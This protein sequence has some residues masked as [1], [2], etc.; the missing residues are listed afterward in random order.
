[1]EL[2]W[3][4]YAGDPAWTPPLRSEV[5][6]LLDRRANPYFEHASAAYFLAL[7]DGK[8]VGRISAQLC[9]LVQ[10]HMGQG[11]GQWG[12]STRSMTRWSLPPCSAPLKPGCAI[13]V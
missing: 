5:K 9:D 11:T 7:R 1:M 8:P 10:T 3:S 13:R 12:F 4:L 2:A 6:G